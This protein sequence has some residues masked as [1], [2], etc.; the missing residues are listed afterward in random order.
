MIGMSY[1]ADWL[2]AIGYGAVLGFVWSGSLVLLTPAPRALWILGTITT[3]LANVFSYEVAQRLHPL[4]LKTVRFPAK[5][6]LALQAV[7]VLYFAAF[8]YVYRGL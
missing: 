1:P 2:S 3:A 4:L 8:I 5:A 7:A 6:N